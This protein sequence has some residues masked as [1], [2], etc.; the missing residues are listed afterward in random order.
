M[1]II[2]WPATSVPLDGRLLGDE[3]LVEP[4]PL[5]GLLAI[6]VLPVSLGPR[7]DDGRISAIGAGTSTTL[8]EDGVDLLGAALVLGD[9]GADG[10][11][12]LGVP[13]V[14]ERGPEVLKRVHV[15][16]IR[17]SVVAG[18]VLLDSLLN[19]LDR[20]MLEVAVHRET[21]PPLR[22]VPADRRRDRLSTKWIGL[23]RG[24]GAWLPL[25]L[26]RDTGS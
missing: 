23:G 21:G 11:P 20:L 15:H 24:S 25:G 17:H 26:I 7:R 8:V 16:R 1:T 14:L 9:L 18:I 13:L 22:R 2:S 6:A 10:L 12:D 19:I 3:G 5:D 4:S